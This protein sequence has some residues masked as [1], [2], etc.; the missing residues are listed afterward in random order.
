M[1]EDEGE[2]RKEVAMQFEAEKV[3]T[4]AREATTED[5]LERVTVYRGGMEPEAVRIIEAELHNRGVGPEEIERYR[6][7]HAGQTIFL[8]NGVAARCSYC[9]RAAVAQGWAMHRLWGLLP[10]FPRRFYYCEEH[11]PASV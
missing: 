4:N 6:A 9:Q 1:K 3:L 10:L 8:P 5:L 11:R 7:E 2:R